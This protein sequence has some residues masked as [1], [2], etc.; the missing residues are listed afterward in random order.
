M[1]FACYLIHTPL[2]ENLDW[3]VVPIAWLSEQLLALDSIELVLALASDSICQKLTQRGLFIANASSWP[4]M[5][6]Y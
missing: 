5:P 6:I 3:N 1:L 4:I 2:I